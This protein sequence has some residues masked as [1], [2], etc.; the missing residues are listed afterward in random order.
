MATARIEREKESSSTSSARHVLASILCMQPSDSLLVLAEA[1]TLAVASAI[2][3]SDCAGG[4]DILLA[5]IPDGPGAQLPL[6]GDLELLLLE[7]TVFL[8]MTRRGFT[9]TLARRKASEARAR[10]LT[11]PGATFDLLQSKAVTADYRA[12][13]AAGDALASSLNGV[14]ILSVR[15]EL[16]TDL[17]LD[18]SGGRW[19]A[20]RGLCDRPGDF[21][22]L[23][24]GEVSIAPVNARGILIVDGSIDP[25]GL[26]AE[27][28][29]IHIDGRKVTH[30]EGQRAGGLIAFLESF[31]PDAFNVAEI[32][33][34]MNPGADVTGITV[35]DE[36]A[37]GTAHIGF[38]NNSNMGG[39]SR[40][41]K[42]N[43]PMHIDA[44]L[45][46]G[47]SLFA[48]GRSISPE[49]FYHDSNQTT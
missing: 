47:V 18:V 2:V 32:G 45:H 7:R 16:G 43:V 34:G 44:V 3:Q 11:M 23:P 8:A 37:L 49:A 24:G 38:G 30:I 28:V 31:G 46:K 33:I 26:L 48:D 41:D 13:A 4:F 35:K 9:H 22:N 20:E 21:G 25:L 42:V 29:T 17:E 40:A 14:D 19:F 1:S 6:P 5:V 12:I 15:S 36:K 10:G 27:P 39:F